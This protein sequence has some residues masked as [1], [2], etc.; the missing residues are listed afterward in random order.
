[1]A[2]VLACLIAGCGDAQQRSEQKKE[3]RDL[4]G[5]SDGSVP[6]DSSGTGSAASAY[7][8]NGKRVQL[9]EPGAD[10]KVSLLASVSGD[11]NGDGRDDRAVILILNSVGSGVFYHLNVFLDDGKNEWR[12]VGEEFLG[13]RIKFDFLDIYVEGSVS[14]ITGV[15]IHPDDYGKLVVA[16][17]VRSSEQSYAEE[18]SLYLTRHWKVEDGRLVLIEDY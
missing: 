12:F 7:T 17:S 2:G 4:T 8:I 5:N 10:G 13:D 6:G 14:S 15:P 1:M 11:L 16:F 18:P 3:L 9:G